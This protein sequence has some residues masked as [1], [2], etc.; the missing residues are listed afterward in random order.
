MKVNWVH[1][2][3]LMDVILLVHLVSSNT[4]VSALASIH[5][6]GVRN[7]MIIPNNTFLEFL[8]PVGPY[9][10]SFRRI[11]FIREECCPR[12]PNSGSTELAVE[13]VI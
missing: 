5:A 12:G 9:L 1:L 7:L 8:R 11:W 6:S 13:T 4:A 10:R 2:P 3:Q